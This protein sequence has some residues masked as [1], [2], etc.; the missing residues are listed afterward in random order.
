MVPQP[1]GLARRPLAAGA[2]TKPRPP[3]SSHT[4]QGAI[5][6]AFVGRVKALIEA[7]LG[8][9][10][11]ARASAEEGLAFSNASSNETF[12]ITTLGVL[13]RLE[14]ALGNLEAAGDY[15]RDLPG[16]LLA[17][18]L[19]DPSQ[20]S[21]RMRSRRW[22]PWASSSRHGRTSRRTSCTRRR[23]GS[24]LALEGARR[25]RGLLTA[26]EGDLDA[27][28]AAF[29][30]ALSEH[31]E[32]PWPFERAR[33][34]LCLGTV[35]RQAQQKKAAREALEQALAIFE[36]LGARLWAE[37]ASAELRRISGRRTSSDE[38]TETEHRVAELAAQGA[39]T[40]RSR[41][42]SSWA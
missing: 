25:C 3:T 19:N 14:L 36:E 31:P 8:L 1:A 23:L 42:S 40:R 4:I 30:G 11:Q 41:P 29:E 38:L 5:P 35:R 24:P 17:G 37:K 13:G 33:T 27:A 9:V 6:L 12:A 16:R 20:P 26:A 2:R 34:L 7:D 39:R 15:L 18:G 28:L 21:G 22:S 32:P 10:E